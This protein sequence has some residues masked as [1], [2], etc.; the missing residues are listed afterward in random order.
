MAPRASVTTLALAKARRLALIGFLIRTPLF[1]EG[2][3]DCRSTMRRCSQTTGQGAGVGD[4][5]V[6]TD[7]GGVLAQI[8]LVVAA[9]PYPQVETVDCPMWTC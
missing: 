1:S 3:A 5:G 4:L 9:V 6:H 8:V 2:F 7:A